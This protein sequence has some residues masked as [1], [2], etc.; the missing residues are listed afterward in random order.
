MSGRSSEGFTGSAY[1]AALSTGPFPAGSPPSGPTATCSI[2]ALLSGEPLSPA[3]AGHVAECPFC[4]R[5]AR[6]LKR[7]P[8]EVDDSGGSK[9]TPEAPPS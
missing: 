8:L 2:T 4:S 6:R 5:M 7:L 1:A 3:Q 9:A